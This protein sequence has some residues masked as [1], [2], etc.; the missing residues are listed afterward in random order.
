M[1][2]GRA[3]SGVKGLH[4][5]PEF[6]CVILESQNELLRA[7]YSW[8]QNPVWPL[9]RVHTKSLAME[10]VNF[11][12]IRKGECAYPNTCS[13]LEAFDAC[14]ALAGMIVEEEDAYAGTF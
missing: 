4:L 10:R 2:L 5:T 14:P 11:A 6:R 8:P 7:E 9:S 12:Q 3:E 13:Y 1:P